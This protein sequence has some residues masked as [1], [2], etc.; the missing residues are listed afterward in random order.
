M[1]RKKSRSNNKHEKEDEEEETD[2]IIQISHLN[3]CFCLFIKE[4][5]TIIITSVVVFTS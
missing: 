5:K 4:K 1:K 2:K 3:L